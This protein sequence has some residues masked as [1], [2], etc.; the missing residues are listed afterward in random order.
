MLR[1]KL[2]G[3]QPR[4]ESTDAVAWG[5]L[6]CSSGEGPVMGLERRDRVGQS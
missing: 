2:K 3:R 5:G 4:G 1:E 6:V